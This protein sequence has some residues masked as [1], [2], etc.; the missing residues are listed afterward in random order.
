MLG[1]LP[2][3]MGVVL[4]LGA[5]SVSEAS[6][7]TETK[8]NYDFFKAQVEPI[9]LEKR[10]GHVRCYV[11]HSENS[12]AL[13]LERLSDGAKF[14][15]EEQSRKNFQAVSLLIDTRNWADSRILLHPLAPEAGGDIFHSGGR[16]FASK[17]DPDWKKLAAFAQGATLNGQK[18]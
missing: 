8:L 12:S 9:F 16:Q 2:I 7:Q 11:C 5:L 10:E 17:D 1:R 14:W 15:D 6:A 3:V 18:N 4:G 13:H